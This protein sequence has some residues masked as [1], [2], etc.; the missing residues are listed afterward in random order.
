MQPRLLDMLDLLPVQY[1][2]DEVVNDFL[3]Y[4]S[5]DTKDFGL[6]IRIRRFEETI[7]AV[8]IV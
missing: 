1:V 7:S 3:N 4:P 5:T 2:N 8:Q 6:D